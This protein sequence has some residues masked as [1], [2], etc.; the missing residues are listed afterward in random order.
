MKILI[1]DLIGKEL[2][3]AV[4][5]CIEGTSNVLFDTLWASFCARYSTDWA[6]GGPIIERERINLEPFETIEGKQWASDGE[7]ESD[8]PLVSAMRCYVASKLGDAD[9]NIEVQDD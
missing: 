6:Y 8:S 5:R 9:G 2:D 3:L 1:H 7:W 4:Y